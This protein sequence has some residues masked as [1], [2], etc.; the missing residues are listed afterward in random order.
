MQIHV[1]KIIKKHCCY[2]NRFYIGL[3][4]FLFKALTDINV[5]KDSSASLQEIFGLNANNFWSLYTYH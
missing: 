2:D 5:N 1:L 4:F 3:H